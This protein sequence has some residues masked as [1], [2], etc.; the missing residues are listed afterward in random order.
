MREIPSAIGFITVH[1]PDCDYYVEKNPS[2]G[3]LMQL[4]QQGALRVILTEH[5][6]YCWIGPISHAAVIRQTGVD[7]VCLVLQAVTAV[8]VE[9]LG[10]P[11]AYPWV[12]APDDGEELDVDQRQQA[13]E[14]W[15]KQRLA[16]MKPIV[17]YM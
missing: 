7:G 1:G 5:D 13:L 4:T 2:E 12:F 8:N 17:W 15:L 3:E 16:T 10:V 11:S 9:P 6:L 14:R